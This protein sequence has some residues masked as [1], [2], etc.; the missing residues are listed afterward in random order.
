MA[1]RE[2][3][4][5]LQQDAEDRRYPDDNTKLRQAH[6][7]YARGLIARVREN[8]ADIVA[9]SKSE[10]QYKKMSKSASKTTIS[11]IIS[12]VAT[13]EDYISQQ[14]SRHE[15]GELVELLDG[16]GRHLLSN[17]FVKLYFEMK[18][19]YTAVDRG[20]VTEE[21]EVILPQSGEVED[22]PDQGTAVV[23]SFL[24]ATVPA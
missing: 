6:A 8:G 20:L 22:V 15:A 21:G 12:A 19:F 18:D 4:K 3:F 11:Q 23:E 14:Q 16:L 9:A 7:D 1:N 24:N 13:V 10:G 5:A 2:T 17:A